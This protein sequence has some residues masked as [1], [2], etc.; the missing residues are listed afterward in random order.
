MIEIGK[1][2]Q[3]EKLEFVDLSDSTL[4]LRDASK[5]SKT[6]ERDQIHHVEIS[7][8]KSASGFC[9]T[10]EWGMSNPSFL[11]PTN[12]VFNILNL[13]KRKKDLVHIKVVLKDGCT[14]IVLGSYEL[15]T[16]LHRERN[17]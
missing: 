1:N 2:L 6:I 3:Y 7:G 5:N 13:F 8:V 15:Y 11:L 17:A 4:Y 12:F 9:G 14:F 16:K 10:A